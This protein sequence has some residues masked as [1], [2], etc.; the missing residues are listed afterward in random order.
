MNYDSSLI[1]TMAVNLKR[2]ILFQ[3][4]YGSP[5][6]IAPRSMQPSL[7]ILNVDFS[8]AD[9]D[10]YIRAWSHNNN[11]TLARLHSPHGHH[12]PGTMA[13]EESVTIQHYF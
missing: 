11:V 8:L 7:C 6:P 5:L 2:E 3:L 10:L 13:G 12:Y 1:G 4:K 9:C